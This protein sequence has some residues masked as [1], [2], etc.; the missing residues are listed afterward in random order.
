MRT[1][2]LSQTA[3][4]PTATRSRAS[5]PRRHCAPRRSSWQPTRKRSTATPGLLV[6]PKTA[7]AVWQRRAPSSA[8]FWRP[9]PTVLTLSTPLSPPAQV[10]TTSELRT[11][12]AAR[13][14]AG[15]ARH[16]PHRMDAAHA[17][18]QHLPLQ[19]CPPTPVTE[20]SEDVPPPIPPRSAS[21]S[22]PHRFP[23][24]PMPPR[25]SASTREARA[26]SSTV[27]TPTQTQARR[28]S[29]APTSRGG[30]GGI[31]GD[32]NHLSLPR[33]RRYQSFSSSRSGDDYASE[34]WQRG[35]VG[36]RVTR[37]IST[38]MR[39]LSRVVRS[40]EHEEDEER[41]LG[42]FRVTWGTT[43]RVE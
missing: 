8:W 24:T 26:R 37:S 29:V 14:D 19:L 43:G 1:G 32:G 13:P 38:R 20:E 30:Y 42:W 33:S 40:D 6:P 18:Q 39:R 11:I 28:S 5:T 31:N 27:S 2:M 7:C 36:A 23:S 34:P 17:Q 25:R 21:T 16:D 12:L 15:A 9:W 22:P 4:R 3:R 35:G 10:S 41:Q